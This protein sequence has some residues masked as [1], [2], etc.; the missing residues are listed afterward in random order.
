MSVRVSVLIVSVLLVLLAPAA[1]ACDHARDREE[2]R[3]HACGDSHVGDCAVSV[4]GHER[5]RTCHERACEHACTTDCEALRCGCAHERDACSQRVCGHA[6][7]GDCGAP[8]CSFVSR[9]L[10]LPCC[11]DE[12]ARERAIESARAAVHAWI[13]QQEGVVREQERQRGFARRAEWRALDRY[14]FTE[15][16]ADLRRL[17]RVREQV[18]AQEAAVVAAHAE[19]QRRRDGFDAAVAEVR[20][21]V[22]GARRCICVS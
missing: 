14:N 21:Q 5:G 8:R 11:T 13:A 20:R 18:Q 3:W 15:S 4:C 1:S 17:E 22:V 9:P 12:R 19:L 16:S 10:L 2:C 7:G 6:R